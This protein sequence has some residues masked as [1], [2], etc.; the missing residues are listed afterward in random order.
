MPAADPVAA[1]LTSHRRLPPHA[2]ELFLGLLMFLAALPAPV[3]MP[4]RSGLRSL[5]VDA[6]IGFGVG[7]LSKVLGLASLV[8]LISIF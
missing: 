1:P 4:K 7:L 5:A 6:S 3:L 8:T 2:G